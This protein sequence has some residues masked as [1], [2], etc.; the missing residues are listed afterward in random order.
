[1]NFTFTDEQQILRDSLRGF[2]RVH[3]PFDR[4]VAAIRSDSGWRRDFWIALAEQ[5]GV[6]GIGVPEALGGVGGG[7][8]ENMIVMEEFGRAL[9]VE[10][11]LETVVLGAAAL[12]A[13]GGAVAHQMLPGLV[14]GETILAFAWAEETMRYNLQ[15]IETLARRDGAGWRIDGRTVVVTAAPWA[16]QFL[17]AART[18]G[19][20]GEA[21]GLSLFLVDKDA[22][23]LTL[24]RYPTVDG[25][26]AADLDFKSVC[27]GSEALL[28]EQGEA[29]PLI[30]ALRDRAIAAIAAEA[31]G[32]MEQMLADT[33][34]YVKGR[35]QFGQ[36]LSSFQV[37]Q[38]RLVDMYMQIE[39]ARSAT[40]LATL[41]LDSDARSRARTA[42]SAKVS[43]AGACRYVGQNAVQL[44]G[45]MGMTD[46][47]PASHYFRRTTMIETE[48]GN[49]DDHLARH[50]QLSQ[51]QSEFA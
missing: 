25:R 23:G 4:R 38:H 45:G 1:M 6:L 32:A 28:G 20:A 12:V 5:V 11:Y 19:S 33:R 14:A 41:N 17:V 39:L 29:E 30:E 27:V 13:A 51:Q 3:Y 34:D 49:A 22:P 46:E 44:H 40:Y 24:R 16:D 26:Q 37:L 7:A 18:G 9:V 31:V 8:V 47:L 2:L 48:F 36:P 42:S 10:P 21:G 15:S 43:I 50:A 35:D